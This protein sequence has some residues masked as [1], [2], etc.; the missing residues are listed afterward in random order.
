MAIQTQITDWIA[1]SA[2]NLD[3]RIIELGWPDTWAPG[4]T[5][6][7]ATIQVGDSKFSGQGTDLEP[8]LA[9]V[10]AVVEA[11]ERALK[12][13]AA[14]PNTSGLAGHVD[15]DQAARNALCELIER[16]A[17]FCHYLTG[18]PFC[19]L[20]DIQQLSAAALNWRHLLSVAKPM[21]VEL[22]FASM[23]VPTGFHGIV[24]M[25]FG[26]GATRPFG[27]ILGLGCSESIEVAAQKAALECIGNVAAQLDGKLGSP[28][29]AQ[30]FAGLP[31]PWVFEHLHLGLADSSASVIRRLLG[32]ASFL[33]T[34]LPLG[35]LSITAM[36]LPSVLQTAP[37]HFVQAMS[38]QAQNAFF[39]HLSPE[40][41]NIRRLEA[42]ANR[43]L[44]LSD[45]ESYPHM[46][47]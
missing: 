3:L 29:S 17:F 40:A 36:P 13:H 19:S 32:S 8:D 41:L 31:K 38:P 23:T 7:A 26:A 15:A 25:A 24:C 46:M 39:G 6:V 1:A 42:F 30:D 43:A 12:D 5:A 34:P 22:N 18:T 10:K 16:D 4:F 28:L 45:I 33:G 37:L 2:N 20:G 21:G 9:V 27:V 14:L 47:A 11:I 35:E 44:G